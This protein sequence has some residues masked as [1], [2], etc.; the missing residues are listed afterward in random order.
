MMATYLVCVEGDEDVIDD[1]KT[2][3]A[4]DLQGAAEEYVR[5]NFANLDYPDECDVF[6]KREGTECH[7]V[8]YTVCAMRDVRF[9]AH[10]A[11]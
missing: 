1:A 3:E 10:P 5:L 2:V 6:V 8:K 4:G 7:P 9:W 11:K